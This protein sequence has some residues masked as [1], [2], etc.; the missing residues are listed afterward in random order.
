MKK[1]EIVFLLC[2]II[3]LSGCGNNKNGMET[4]ENVQNDSSLIQES[5]SLSQDK[6]ESED[7]N[8]A[9]TDETEKQKTTM[10]NTENTRNFNTNNTLSSI[11]QNNV[12]KI[13]VTNG[14]TGEKREIDD[15]EEINNLLE[16][17]K[18]LKIISQAEKNV[19][20]YSYA[21][22]LYTNE[23]LAQNVYVN[24]N[25]IV[26]DGTVYTVESSQNIIDSVR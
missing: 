2:I 22:A 8:F 4:L 21:V 26:I 23:N 16:Q 3:I 9:V 17:I 11:V 10:E 7:A 6:E 24:D 25:T 20:D 12:S 1:V 19:Q 14:S 13:I 15:V 18:E 5:V